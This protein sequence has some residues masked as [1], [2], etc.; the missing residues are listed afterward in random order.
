METEH[1]NFLNSLIISNL[2]KPLTIIMIQ[3]ISQENAHLKVNQ[4]TFIAM[5]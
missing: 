2:K 3:D 5:T 1:P 4:I